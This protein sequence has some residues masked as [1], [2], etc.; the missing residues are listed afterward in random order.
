MATP[1]SRTSSRAPRTNISAKNQTTITGTAATW[2]NQGRARS[3]HIVPPHDADEGSHVERERPG[4]DRGRDP[5]SQSYGAERTER[6]ANHDSEGSEPEEK[7][8]A[9]N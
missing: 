5:A 8:A 3:A 6:D 2:R 7:V 4:H 9:L 1:I